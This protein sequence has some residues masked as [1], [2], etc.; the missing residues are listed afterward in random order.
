MA[1]WQ[2]NLDLRDIWSMGEDEEKIPELAGIVATRLKA[3]KPFGD[4]DIDDEKADIV[5]DFEELAKMKPEDCTFDDFN[6]T[7][8][9][10][11]DW[12]DTHLD[13]EWNGK[14]VAWIGTF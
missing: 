4:E 3:L 5:Q 2:R 1:N 10:L 6:N 13:D 14:R 9:R 7:L 11:Y 12:G 8:D